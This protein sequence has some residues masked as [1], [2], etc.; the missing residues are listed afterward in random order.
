M[1]DLPSRDEMVAAIDEMGDG[2]AALP[3]AIQWACATQNPRDARCRESL[4][5]ASREPALLRKAA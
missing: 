4:Q 5:L 3:G 2:F 1:S